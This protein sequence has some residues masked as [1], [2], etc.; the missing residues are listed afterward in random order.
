MSWWRV[1][2]G[3]IIG[4]DGKGGGSWCVWSDILMWLFRGFELVLYIPYQAGARYLNKLI[5]IA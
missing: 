5:Q 4:E 1:W 2:I 3:G